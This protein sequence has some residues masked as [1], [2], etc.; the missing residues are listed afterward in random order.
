MG[1]GGTRPAPALT[2]ALDTCAEGF[3]FAVH[4]GSKPQM[5]CLVRMLKIHF[6][7]L[8]AKLGNRICGL[9]T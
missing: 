3:L 2:K 8:G 9:D 5:P 4:L 1:R 6:F 7:P